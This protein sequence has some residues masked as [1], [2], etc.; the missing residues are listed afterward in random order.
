MGG[1]LKLCGQLMALA[2]A[3]IL[4]PLVFV[5][6]GFLWMLKV[7]CMGVLHVNLF[8]VTGITKTYDW[9]LNESYL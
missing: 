4:M 1:N 9:L 7:V 3:V 2:I 5:V 8:L 6:M